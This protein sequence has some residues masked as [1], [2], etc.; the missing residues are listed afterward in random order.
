[1][2]IEKTIRITLSLFLAVSVGGAPVLGKAS[3]SKIKQQPKQ[4]VLQETLPNVRVLIEPNPEGP[5]L[6]FDWGEKKPALALMKGAVREGVQEWW[7]V[8]DDRATISLPNLQETPVPGLVSMDA[9]KE[10]AVLQVIVDSGRTPVIAQKD[11]QW[12][13]FFKEQPL[14]VQESAVIRLPQTK[15]EGL[16]ISLKAL[17]KEVR[18]KDPRTGYVHVIFPS[19]Q[20][21]FGVP[22]GQVFPEF[23]ISAMAQGVGFQ[24]LKDGVVIDATPDQAM[25]TH[26]EGL[27][28]TLPQEREQ[29]RVRAMPIGF[30]ADA[31]E[32]DWVSQQQKINEGLLDL[33][34]DQHGPGELEIAWLLLSHGQAAQALGY[35]TH[36]AQMRP[37]ITNLPLF[38]ALCGV[39]NLL[40][41]RF[42][43]CERY[44]S[45]LPEEPE[46]QMWLS[47]VN[48]LQRPLYFSAS[49]PSLTH[50]RSQFQTAK[51]LLQ[52]YPKP[53][54]SQMVT[55]ILKACIAMGDL[56]ILSSFLD[57]EMRPQKEGEEREI[58]DLAKAIVLMSQH[59][60]DA[61][62]Q[63]L[64]ELIEKGASA[65]VRDIALFNYV[66]H[67]LETKMMEE[68]D[69]FFQLNRLCSQWQG[70]WLGHRVMTYLKERKPHP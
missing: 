5:A 21:G 7:I 43:I 11:H 59:K 1:M 49:P 18:F 34:H 15:K 40:L 31:Q 3:P 61:A 33:P 27:A 63:I 48:V 26:P 10:S 68:G 55:L 52:S 56:E 46:A 44:L 23:H 54:R 32:L 37:S 67:R 51:S 13:V 50:L 19:H 65:E 14:T 9:T 22:E 58:F 25:V 29:V 62:L 70:G 20:V 66:V 38:A 45:A 6:H 24:L 4:N 41:N 35:L 39:G 28:I 36:L 8:F 69:A 53:L 64:G 30:F 42:P 60:P 2:R 12:Q 57:Q 47:L 16:L 17:G